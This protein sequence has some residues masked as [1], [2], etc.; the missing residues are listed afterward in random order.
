MRTPESRN[1]TRRRG[2]TAARAAGGRNGARPTLGERGV[3]VAEGAMQFAANGALED[4]LRPNTRD[5]DAMINRDPQIQ[6]LCQAAVLPLL[7]AEGHVEE[8]EEDDGEAELVSDNLTGPEWDRGMKTPILA[9]LEQEASAMFYRQAFFEKVW[10][11]D[12]DGTFRYEKLAFRHALSCKIRQDPENGSFAGFTQEGMRP[13]GGWFTEDF[14]PLY[15]YVYVH[16]AAQRPMLGTTLLQ[17]PWHEHM[18]K[19]KLRWLQFRGFAKFGTGILHVK[20]A[21]TSEEEIAD[22]TDHANQVLDGGVLVTADDEEVSLLTASGQT[23]FLDTLREINNDMA[24]AFLLP[25]L[26]LGQGGNSGAWA[27]ARTHSDLFIMLCEARLNQIAENRTRYMIAPLVYQNRGPDAAYPS[28]KFPGL[29]DEGRELAK[30]VFMALLGRPQASVHPVIK[31]TAEKEVARQ[32][33]A[34]PD[35]IPEHDAPEREAEQV[36]PDATGEGAPPTDPERAAEVDALSG[37]IDAL[38]G[39]VA[40]GEAEDGTGLG[41]LLGEFREELVRREGGKFA[42]KDGGSFA[43]GAQT[44]GPGRP[45]PGGSGAD[46]V[47]P[48]IRQAEQQRLLGLMGENPT[49]EKQERV[50]RGEA[51]RLTAKA[52]ALLD[53]RRA[54]RGQEEAAQK[55]RGQ[56]RRQKAEQNRNEENAERAKKGLPPKQPDKPKPSGASGSKTSSASKPSGSSAGKSGSGSGSSEASVAPLGE[57]RTVYYRLVVVRDMARSRNIRLA[58]GEGGDNPLGESVVVLHGGPDDPR[59]IP[60]HDQSTHGRRRRSVGI[61]PYRDISREVPEALGNLF[62]S[63]FYREFEEAFRTQAKD[64]DVEVVDF[65]RA[66]GLWEGEFEP[67]AAAVVR[68]NPERIRGLLKDLGRRYRQESVMEIRYVKKGPDN[69][70]RFKGVAPSAEARD[71]IVEHGFLGARF[72][73]DTLEIAD[74]GAQNRAAALRLASTLGARLRIMPGRVRFLEEGEDY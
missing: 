19:N 13:N 31:A 6:A 40:A 70:Y 26:M 30:E 22:L 53:E 16:G 39:E 20:T 25:Q 36:P 2:R 73:G 56:E 23:Q 41:V 5:V 59:D 62:D 1:G 51:E 34:D 72:V 27:L 12:E 60:D 35:L 14:D 4:P 57:L 50:L 37:A 7:F 18:H 28:W 49:R 71:A 8:A 45:G 15:A 17:A 74:P 9:V 48:H 55:Q 32:M 42:R 46:R 47:P 52:R 68:G 66:L 11:R 63:P 44:G 58:A 38:R 10:T 21:R 24:R 64:L 69:I 43:S 65:A 29:T 54:A 33:G 3:G 61:S 67:A